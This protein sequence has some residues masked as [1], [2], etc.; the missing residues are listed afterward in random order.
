MSQYRLGLPWNQESGERKRLLVTTIL[1]VPL[2]VL[3]AGYIS[4]VELPEIE[5]EE[6]EA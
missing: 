6:R 5:R 4:W 1:L 2:F 3:V